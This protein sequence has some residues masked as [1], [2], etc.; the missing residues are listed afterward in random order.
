MLSKSSYLACSC[1][2][3][4]GLRSHGSVCFKSPSDYFTS[5]SCIHFIIS[6][7]LLLFWVTNSNSNYKQVMM[8]HESMNI[9]NNTIKA[10]KKN[11]NQAFILSTCFATSYHKRNKLQ[12]HHSLEINVP[13]TKYLKPYSQWNVSSQQNKS[14]IK[15]TFFFAIHTYI[16]SHLQASP[17]HF[18][19]QLLLKRGKREKI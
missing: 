18:R 13:N 14:Y 6:I 4:W 9:C 2:N 12:N 17:I 10:R 16:L 8:T 3:Y 5:S 11:I 19:Q 15:S 7:I 1:D